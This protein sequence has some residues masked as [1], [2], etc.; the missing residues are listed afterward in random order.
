MARAFYNER[1]PK[2]AA[3]LRDAI[4]AGLV[5]PGTVDERDVRDILPSDLDGYDQH[6][7]FAGIGIW[8]LA[9]RWAGWPDDRPVWT[10]SCPCQPFSGAGK[11]LGFADERHVWPLWHWLIAQRRPDTIFGEQVSSVDGLAWF[12]LVS[13]DLEGS[14]YAIGARDSCSA[15]VGAPNIRQ[16]LYWVADADSPGPEEQPLQLRQK[17]SGD[18]EIARRSGPGGLGDA[19]HARLPHAEPPD[20]RGAQRH[21]E[22]R[23]I[24]EPSCPPNPWREL[25]WIE[26]RDGKQRPVESA[27]VRLASG[28]TPELAGLRASEG[29]EIE[30]GTANQISPEPLLS[31]LRDQAGAQTSKRRPGDGT[32]IQSSSLLQSN[33]HGGGH[34]GQNQESQPEELPQAVGKVGEGQLRVVRSDG[35]TART[36]SGL[37]SHEQHTEQFEDVVRLL[38]P[39]LTL[40]KSYRDA[41]TENALLA[42]RQAIHKSGAVQHAS[43]STAEIWR[44]LDDKSQNRIRMAFDLRGWRTVRPYPLAARH[45]GDVAILRHAGNAINPYVAEAF[46]QAFL[47]NK[48]LT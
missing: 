42:L 12:D 30:H 33:V 9:L 23:A 35:P 19:G 37:R 3:H 31:S 40:A 46:V 20:L 43:D 26:C 22:G 4:A 16:R 34:G 45:P 21:V 47:D 6:H 27:H 39:S 1:D 25:E 14:G 18:S 5:C 32:R 11:G 29:K 8:S 7:F 38:S 15:G 48:K 2:A 36:S 41:G 44:S 28:N 13:S 17:P 10:G 24:A